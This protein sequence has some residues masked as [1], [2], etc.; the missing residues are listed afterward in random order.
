MTRKICFF[1]IDGTLWDRENRIPESAVSAIRRLR[2]NG[3]QALICSGRSRSYIR[4]PDLL[5]IGFDGIVS[6]AGTMLELDGKTVFNRVLPPEAV[7]KAVETALALSWTPL[8]EGVRTTCIDRE[9]FPI[10]PYYDKLARELGDTLEPLSRRWGQWDDISKLTVI[11]REGAADLERLREI[12]GGTFD[13]V[14]HEPW[15]AELV[16]PGVNKGTGL[17][18]ACRALGA[19]PKDS[20]A[21]GDSA[22]DLDMI[23]AAG[24]GVCMGN[25]TEALKQAADLVAA[26]M[27]DDGIEKALIALG[28][29]GAEEEA[30]RTES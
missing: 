24:T 29:I 16:P 30:G 9:G 4:H 22:N 27:E 13:F 18:E 28:L 2:A 19:D 17:T 6:G 1:D 5:A 25:G 20:V 11:A 8:L 12:L 26:S 3:H 14:I 21:F 7:L 23:R 10:P 15:L